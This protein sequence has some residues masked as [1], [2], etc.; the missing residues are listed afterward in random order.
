MLSAAIFLGALR[1]KLCLKLVLSGDFSRHF[2]SICTKFQVKLDLSIPVFTIIVLD[3]F[4]FNK[5]F[6]IFLIFDFHGNKM[7]WV[8]V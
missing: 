5:R 2:L 4:F 7:L 1:V 3:I 8:L 6:V